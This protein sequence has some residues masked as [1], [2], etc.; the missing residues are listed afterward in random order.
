METSKKIRT[1]LLAAAIGLTGYTQTVEMNNIN[2][3]EAEL[4][5]CKVSQKTPIEVCSKD[6]NLLVKETGKAQIKF[7]DEYKKNDKEYKLQ[8]DKIKFEI[9]QDEG[10]IK[11]NDNIEE[12]DIFSSN[13]YKNISY[14]GLKSGTAKIKA[15]ATYKSK[16]N[17]KIEKTV[18]F[19]VKVSSKDGIPKLKGFR[20]GTLNETKDSIK[21]KGYKGDKVDFSVVATLKNSDYKEHNINKIIENLE[22][23]K[24]SDYVSAVCKISESNSSVEDYYYPGDGVKVQIDCEATILKNSDHKQEI[25]FSFNPDSESALANPGGNEDCKKMQIPGKADIYKLAILAPNRIQMHIPAAKTTANENV[26]LGLDYGMLEEKKATI[27]IQNKTIATIAV[28]GTAARVINPGTESFDVNALKAGTTSINV[29]LEDL[30]HGNAEKNKDN[31]NRKTTAV[32]EV[33]VTQQA[34][35]TPAP[36]DTCSVTRKDSLG[37]IT[38]RKICFRNGNTERITKFT[39]KGNS[40]NYNTLT[41]EQYS[42]AKNNRILTR[43]VYSNYLNNSTWRKRVVTRFNDNNGNKRHAQDITLRHNNKRTRENVHRRYFGNGKVR[44]YDLH[45][46]NSKGVRTARRSNQYFSN[47]VLRD[48]KLWSNFSNGKHKRR[49]FVRRDETNRIMRREVAT[50]N[51]RGQMLRKV[52]H[53]YNKNG[54]LRG[55]R[56]LR[57]W[58]VV[59]T[60]RNGKIFRTVR[61]DY[62]AAGKLV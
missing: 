40:K 35:V 52:E 6:E 45:R 21:I 54:K 12:D 9:I 10:V 62:N 42:H 53:R 5:T 51:N 11:L 50:F 60:Y 24:G 37:R 4:T 8:K 56:G 48:S 43:T 7:N 58:R 16:Y 41:V 26:K 3:Q 29:E 34:V 44:H 33:V 20:A 27:D 2:A 46:Y 61:K 25:E 18:D 39:Y 13:I 31:E 19:E 32:I 22:F 14:T 17:E 30:T 55:G 59:Q 38:Y 57:A 49:V 28:N 47:G 1:L 15:S 36:T 23:T